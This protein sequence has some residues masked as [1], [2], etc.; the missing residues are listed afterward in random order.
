MTLGGIQGN[1][2]GGFLSADLYTDLALKRGNLIVL[3]RANFKSILMFARGP[4]GDMNRK[5]GVDLSKYPDAEIILILTALVAESDLL[6]N[7]HDGSGFY[8]PT[9]ESELAD[10]NRYGQSIIADTEVFMPEG[11]KRSLINLK[12]MA[13]QAIA[14]INSEIDDF[15]Y[16]FHFMNT[17]TDQ[18]KSKHK[19][20]QHLA[21]YYA[22]TKVGIPAFGGETSKQLPIL[23][24]KV[25][26]HNLAV[27][28]F[29]RLLGVE[30]EHPRIYLEPP[31]LEYMII[32]V[33]GQLPVAMPDRHTP[34]A[35]SK[36]TTEVVYVGA[37]YDQGL[38]V[39]IIGE[40]AL[41]DIRRR[42]V[43]T[44]PTTIVAQKDH[45]KFGQL[46]IDLVK[47]KNDPTLMVEPKVAQVKVPDGQDSEP[48]NTAPA[49]KAGPFKIT[50]FI[51]AMDSKT[52]VMKPGETTT[53]ISGAKIKLIDFKYESRPP[54]KRL[55]LNFKGFTPKGEYNGGEDRGHLINTAA[56][57]PI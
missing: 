10:P 51:I 35:Q 23:E 26:Q 44:K 46:K 43:I 18:L 5:F 30:V 8:W 1:E 37:N 33:N 56:R 45:L 52:V 12:E 7:L 9:Q 29:M 54:A 19:G 21:T 39:N 3:P 31:K 16:K 53:L 38:S 6:L 28:A 22:L 14:E 17:N 27:N 25:R 41:N 36:G 24:M 2:P 34:G 20:P 32:S 47:N 40:G 42:L 11:S 57:P 15:R 55:V 50:E 13:E 49:K 4:F 48:V